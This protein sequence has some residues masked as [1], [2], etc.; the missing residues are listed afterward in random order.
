MIPANKEDRERLE[1]E[2][3]VN[4]EELGKQLSRFDEAACTEYYEMLIGRRNFNKIQD[5]REYRLFLIM[6]T[7]YKDKFPTDEDVAR[8]FQITRLQARN[9]LR[10]MNAK[11]KYELN[12]ILPAAVKNLLLGKYGNLTEQSNGDVK[13]KITN[14][15]LKEKLELMLASS[16]TSH[17][18][19]RKSDESDSTYVIP[20]DSMDFLR[21]ELKMEE[22][23][24]DTAVQAKNKRKN[25]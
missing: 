23:S 18:K 20:K 21:I 24:K 3:G 19:M 1:I 5:L 16:T 14:E 13:L 11:Y 15:N 22:K 9:L 10:S 8:I 25:K 4:E 12:K 6:T 17:L 2:L 7:V